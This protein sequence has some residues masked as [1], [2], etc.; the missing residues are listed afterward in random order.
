MIVLYL[1][2]FGMLFMLL[3]MFLSV[4]DLFMGFNFALYYVV[5]F[6]GCIGS[7]CCCTAV[8]ALIV[9]LICLIM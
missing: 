1:F 2:C 8:L 5:A 9:D 7:A 4:I 3:A 6:I